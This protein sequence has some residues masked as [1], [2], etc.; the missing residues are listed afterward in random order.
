MRI[1]H[2]IAAAAL[3]ITPALAPTLPTLPA[4]AAAPAP[5]FGS[6]PAAN[7]AADPPSAEAGWTWPLSPRPRVARFFDPPAKP[8]LSGHRGVDL[9]ADSSNARVLSP[10]AG[11][12]SFVGMVVDRPVITVDHGNG[13]RSSFEPVR[14][15]LALGSPVR[16][17]EILGLLEA[18]HCDTRPCLHW[19]VRR[20]EEYLNPLAFVTDLRPSILL[21]LG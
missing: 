6:I 20:G 8:W 10:E 17:G 15:H 4:R 13:L 18:G 21:P 9:A 16:K 14:S 12:V 19:G 5:A 11:T 1:F 3:V 2:V 7:F